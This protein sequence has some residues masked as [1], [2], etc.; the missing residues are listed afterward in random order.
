MSKL[1]WYKTYARDSMIATMHLSHLQR[2]TLQ[3]MM[4][5]AWDSG[6]CSIP[7]DPA[8]LKSVLNVTDEEYEHDIKPVIAE[9][10]LVDGE[11]LINPELRLQWITALA[12]A[13][14]RRTRARNAV[15]VRW[16]NARARA[17]KYGK[18]PASDPQ[19]GHETAKKLSH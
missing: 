19:N 14:M 18:F 8:S 3:R 7:S 5:L 1:P 12:S 2:S 17:A 15:K 4:N 6:H 11:Q 9:F 10:W 16:A 13:E